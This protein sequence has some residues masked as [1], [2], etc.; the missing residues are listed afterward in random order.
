MKTIIEE[1]TEE[2]AHTTDGPVTEFVAISRALNLK[3]ITTY[4]A[5][6]IAE[7]L[8]NVLQG[9]KEHGDIP[10]SEQSACHA[11]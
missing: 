7:A 6:D 4:G 3:E 2:I 9:I 1:I 11:L 8:H 5:D 10:S